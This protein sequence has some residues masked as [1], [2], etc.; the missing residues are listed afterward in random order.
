MTTS[1]TSPRA[2]LID[3]DGTLADS[4]AVMRLAY[5]QFLEGFQ[6]QG[7][8]DE[9]ASLNGPPLHEVVRRL[10][11]NHSL[12]GDTDALTAKYFHIIDQLYDGVSPSPGARELLTK[13]KEHGCLVCIVTSNSTKRTQGWLTLVGLAQCVDFIVSGDE[14]KLGKPHPEPYLLASHRV[15]C[16]ITGII[17]V[18]DSIQGGQSAIAAGLKTYLVT[19]LNEDPDVLHGAMLASSLGCLVNDLWGPA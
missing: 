9:F 10:K 16:P 8:D 17:A 3:L 7:T 5:Q 11:A 2:I 6:V 15:D 1:L 19:S 12:A 14:V 13:A 18:E 4:L